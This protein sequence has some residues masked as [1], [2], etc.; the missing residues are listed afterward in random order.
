MQ[1][2]KYI[3][4]V[5]IPNYNRLEKFKSLLENIATQIVC[6]GLQKKVEVCIS[7]D[8][9]TINPISIVDEVKK[10][11][12][13][14]YIQYNRNKQNM[15]MDYNFLKSVLLANGRYAWII[16][17]D[18]VPEDKAL[19][20]ILKIIHKTK[21]ED[22]DFI[23]TSFDSFDYANN[24][25]KT[26]S[27]FGQEDHEDLVFN[28]CDK[29]Q[30]YNLIMKVK[31]N[32]AVFG[33][34]SNVVFKRERWIRHGNRFEDKM[35]TIFIQVYMNLQTLVEGAKYFYTPQKIIL[36]Y[37]DDEMNQT[38]DRTYQ[39]AVGLYEAMDYF[40]Q[41]EERRSI[42]KN[43]VD[44]FIS[45]RFM[46]FPKNDKRRM[47]ID[48]FVSE[49]LDILNKYYIKCKDRKQ[50]FDK[51]NI[52]IYGAGKFGCIAIND[53]MNFKANIIGICDIDKQKQGKYI[54]GNIIFDFD[55]LLKEYRKYHDCVIVVA[56][57]IHL[58]EI[59]H[60]LIENLV[61]QIAIIT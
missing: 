53:L 32:S 45:S 29:K 49:R 60:K 51:K 58:V 61:F 4:S 57:N 46:E 50:Y 25:I 33:F 52:I 44:V 36:N 17:N 55:T 9:S 27:P 11:F 37:L 18:D 42:E 19:Y 31:D 41:G 59:I 1:E 22:I 15:G 8:F 43:V 23:V 7:D 2:E 10:K 38:I 26:V 5:C 12:P 21:Y 47:K 48:K 3:L 34:L 28:T 16:G 54:E 40:F 13:L 39:I 6:D 14:V 30:L 24:F 56:N 20:N 35:S